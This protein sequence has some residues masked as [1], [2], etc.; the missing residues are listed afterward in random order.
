M[1]DLHRL[2][3]KLIQL[4]LK[5]M[6]QNLEVTLKQASEKNQDTLF[7]I[8]HLLHL[9]AEHRWHNAIKLRFQ[10]SKLNEKLT[11]DQFDFNHVSGDLKL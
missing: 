9:E 3:D 2:K 10:Q 11:I 7:V 5:T 8:N 4:R 6:A 1:T